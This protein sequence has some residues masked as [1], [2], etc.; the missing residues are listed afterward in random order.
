M[1]FVRI[2]T[3][4]KIHFFADRDYTEPHECFWVLWL[5]LLALGQVGAQ[6]VIKYNCASPGVSGGSGRS[7]C[8]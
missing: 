2:K 5:L 8:N 4:M 7:Q 3:R 6:G 1:R